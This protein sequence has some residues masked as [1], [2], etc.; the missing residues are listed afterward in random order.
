MKNG[1]R[2]L[3]RICG[4]AALVFSVVAL[5]NAQQP[6]A[7]GAGRG[8][9]PKVTVLIA[10][11]NPA[12][13]LLDKE[14]G[15]AVTDVNFWRA[16]WSP[17][18]AGAV[19]FVTVRNS[20]D[21]DLRVAIADNEKLADYVMN[22]LMGSFGG[23]NSFASPPY[24]ILKG[25]VTQTNVGATERTETCKSEKYNIV[26]TW[27]DLGGATWVPE[28]RPGNANIVQS[29]VMVQAKG[30]EVTINGKKAPGTYYPTGGGFGPGAFLTLNEAWRREEK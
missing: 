10:A 29:F 24:T 3:M 11:E 18:G 8:P 22:S 5:A 28:F 12:L 25:T 14:G 4:A 26:I 19:C 30:A 13:R 20:G 27:K 9:G 2:E 23:T 1:I 7:G 15:K 6:P 21:A 17:V 16:Q